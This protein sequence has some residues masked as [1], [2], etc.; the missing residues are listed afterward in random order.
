MIENRKKQLLEQV[1]IYLNRAAV[2]FHFNPPDI[3]VDFSLRGTTAG[4][5]SADKRLIRLNV[6]KIEDDTIFD[7]ILTKTVPHEVAHI[8]QYTHPYWPDRKHNPPHGLYW[9]RVMDRFG[10]PAEPY[11][12][13]PLP[14]ARKQ[15]TWSY[16]CSC[17]T[18]TLSTCRHNRIR[19]GERTYHCTVCKA[20]LVKA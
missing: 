17:R 3:R 6:T 2:L 16:K 14:P 18:H 8:I 10:V 4:T 15:K 11:H 13:L 19:N 12:S 9:R 1:D 20:N 5:A 7:H